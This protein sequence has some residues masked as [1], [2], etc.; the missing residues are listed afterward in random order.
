MLRLSSAALAIGLV[1]ALESP[2]LGDEPNQ[3]L[4]ELF[5]SEAVFSQGAGETQ[6]TLLPRFVQHRDGSAEVMPFGF[7]YGIT[8]SWQLEADWDSYIRDN[9]N[10]LPVAQG[11]GDAD[12]GTRYSWMHIDDS[13]VSAALGFNVNAPLAQKNPRLGEE[14]QW[15]AQPYGVIALDI[16]HWD[17]AQMFS[18]IG[19]NWNLN[20]GSTNAWYANFGFYGPIGQFTV[21]GELNLTQEKDDYVTPGLIWR[22][23]ENL[24]IGVGVPVGLNNFSDRYRVILSF[25]DEFGDGNG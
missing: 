16:P 4:Q 12:L 2:V 14:N 1:L 23:R 10:G 11:I 25:T 13:P 5:Q 19:G 9:R 7:E 24:F 3:P 18:N 8:D 6:I 20:R 15:Q 21:T 17:T 22:A